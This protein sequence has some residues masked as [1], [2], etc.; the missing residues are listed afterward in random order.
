[1]FEQKEYLDLD[2]LKRGLES[3]I[4]KIEKEKPIILINSQGFQ[5]FLNNYLNKLYNS[6]EIKEYSKEYIKGLNNVLE[7]INYLTEVI[8]KNPNT[9]IFII[10][11]E[12][13]EII[14]PHET[15]SSLY[16]RFKSIEDNLKKVYKNPQLKLDLKENDKIKDSIYYK[17]FLVNYPEH[18]I[19]ELSIE[20]DISSSFF[21]EDLNLE[22]IKLIEKISNI[23]NLEEKEKEF[24]F[25][26]T[27]T[28]IKK[29]E[30]EKE[31]KVDISI[32]L[33]NNLSIPLRNKY[34]NN[35]EVLINT[36]KDIER[37]GYQLT[38]YKV[39]DESSIKEKASYLNKYKDKDLVIFPEFYLMPKSF[40]RPIYYIGLAIFPENNKI[41]EI[42]YL[43][44]T[45]YISSLFNLKN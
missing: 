31:G 2:T 9:L 10:D 38:N 37:K 17:H 29:I 39:I 19:L 1:M 15:S 22:R 25:F 21:N 28:S 8:N 34:L 26:N 6:I 32:I 14:F 16:Q 41:M 7:K 20:K 12:N 33:H 42:P 43:I 44:N 30:E 11:R 24:A 35:L 45:L 40:Y 18:N 27:L 23:L 36:I 3:L 4:K 5:I 13:K